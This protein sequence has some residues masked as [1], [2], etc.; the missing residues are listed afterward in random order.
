MLSGTPIRLR[1]TLWYVVLL[2]MILAVF[3]AGVYLILR[4]ALYHNLDESMLN[5]ASTLL[6][7]IQYEGDR[8]FLPSE[9]SWGGPGQDENFA[10]VFDA[11]GNLKF[12]K[13]VDLK[14]VPSDAEA[15]VNALRGEYM[16]RRVKISE[17]N[18]LIRVK[19]LPI[20]RDGEIIGVLEVGQSEDGVSNTLTS[21]L[22]IMI[23]AY[24]IALLAASFSGMFLAGR[25]FSR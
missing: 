22:Q 6:S 18:D 23:L 24:P 21:L 15:V 11:S 7:V 2:A 5:R 25:A 17:D 13:A 9:V 14:Q 8:L 3:I 16:T 10:R 1:L 19:T 12:G 20:I 4:Q